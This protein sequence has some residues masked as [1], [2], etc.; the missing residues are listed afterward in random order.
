MKK[1]LEITV[2]ESV[3]KT[4]IPPRIT[5]EVIELEQGIASGSAAVSPGGNNDAVKEEWGT[6]T[7]RDGGLDW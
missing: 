1:R 6:G 7:N 4:Y 5:S 3:K 2:L